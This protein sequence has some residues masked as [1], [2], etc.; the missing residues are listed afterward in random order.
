MIGPALRVVATLIL[1]WG[2]WWAWRSLRADRT[3]VTIVGIGLAVR[4]I[5]GALL[6]WVSYLELPAGA[7]MQL[8]NGL[9][10]Y[11]LD[12]QSY[13]K[14]AEAAA[15]LGLPGIWNL[16][17]TLPS[18]T[19]IQA[20]ALT[21]YLVGPV[22]SA[23]LLLNLGAYLATCV[24]VVWIARRVEAARPALLL[25]LAAVSLTPSWILWSTQPLKDT[26]FIASIVV[27]TAPLVVWLDWLRG[28]RVKGR[29][30]VAA[31]LLQWAAFYAVAGVRWYFALFLL[32]AVA[33]GSV[34]A[35][36]LRR[37]GRARAALLA[38]LAVVLLAQ[39]V[40]TAAGP[41]V[42]E[43]IR[44]VLRPP[45]V[46]V[47]LAALG[48]APGG[49]RFMVHRARL[50]HVV[51]GGGTEIRTPIRELP[52]E[53]L[54]ADTAG[55]PAEGD[56]VG[57]AMAIWS[58]LTAGERVFIGAVAM[59]VPR[60]VGETAGWVEI[61]GGRGLFAFAELDTV[62]LDVVILLAAALIV[63]QW[64]AGRVP[65]PAFWFVLAM[66]ILVAVPL[67]YQAGNF[68]TLF[69]QRNMVAVGVMVLPLFMTPRREPPGA[70]RRTFD[71][72]AR[73]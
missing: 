51:A 67:A 3:V 21:L 35:L 65:H 69:R 16:D 54:R 38:A 25:A 18:G 11:A 50:G 27:F 56:G 63:W 33:V 48:E 46:E 7:S 70:D 10:F 58:K 62:L 23:A 17:P 26:F 45:S 53:F 20:L 61:G 19:Y 31:L 37:S 42:P 39:A 22:T 47:A 55:F 60:V 5:A 41:Y 24:A 73:T 2:L 14:F 64:R 9:W 12:G 29:V 13:F 57:E 1:A 72:T 28:D 15:A 66:T 32:V 44:N 6:F 30:V 8:G 49:T 71:A 4:A 43:W 36:M 68:G 59:L 52:V 40:P 34:W